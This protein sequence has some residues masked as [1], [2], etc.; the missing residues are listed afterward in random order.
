VTKEYTSGRRFRPCPRVDRRS[1][2]GAGHDGVRVRGRLY[3]KRLDAFPNLAGRPIPSNSGKQL[4]SERP[5][6]HLRGSKGQ[7]GQPRRAAGYP[8]SRANRTPG[9]TV[10]LGSQAAVGVL[11]LANLGMQIVEFAFPSRQLP[12]QLITPFARRAELRL[13]VPC[14]IGRRRRFR[15]PSTPIVACSA[16]RRAHRRLTCSP[17]R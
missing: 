5:P 2:P 13:L 8:S 12:F 11:Q 4:E 6:H 14:D 16:H 3:N 7:P 10:K 15:K 17:R 1:S 9:H